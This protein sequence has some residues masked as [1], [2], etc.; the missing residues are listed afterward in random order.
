MTTLKPSTHWDLI[1][2][3]TSL[4]STYIVCTKLIKYPFWPIHNAGLFYYTLG[5]LDPELLSTLDSIC[6]F[7]IVKVSV[8]QAHGIDAVLEPFVEAVKKLEVRISI[9]MGWLF[10]A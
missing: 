5:N 10:Y 7:T 9:I 3:C 4:V 2:K 8:I 6:L 1:Q